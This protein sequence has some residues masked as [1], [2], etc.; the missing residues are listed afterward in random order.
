[1]N[2]G[3][4]EERSGQ[5]FCS[6]PA[7]VHCYPYVKVKERILFNVRPGVLF[8]HTFRSG[9]SCRYPSERPDCSFVLFLNKSKVINTAPIRISLLTSKHPR[10]STRN[11]NRM[12]SGLFSD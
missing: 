9:R 3:K 10:I 2:E 8:P 5:I 1:M 7:L 12:A 11:R 4:R 6:S